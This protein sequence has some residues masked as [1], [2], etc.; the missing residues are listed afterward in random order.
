MRAAC[1]EWVPCHYGMVRSQAVDGRDGLQMWKAVA[2]IL[3]KQS[4]TADDGWYSSLGV[5]RLASNSS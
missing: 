1:P 4:R 5:A 3:N 2:N